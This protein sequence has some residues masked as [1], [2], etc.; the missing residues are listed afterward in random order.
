[1]P[2]SS[3]SLPSAVQEHRSVAVLAAR[4]DEQLPELVVQA[5][6]RHRAG[7]TDL[8][9]LPAADV[10]D[11]VHDA[12]WVVAEMALVAMRS[13]AAAA[14][15]LPDA[16]DRLTGLAAQHDAGAETVLGLL[17]ATHA[18]LLDHALGA[19]EHHGLPL[20][21]VER[22]SRHL[23][24]YMDRLVALVTAAYAEERERL[25]AR[26]EGARL[27]R[28]RAV[29]DGADR[30][31]LPYPLDGR[32][33]ALVLR[34]ARARGHVR[35]AMQRLGAPW[36]VTEEADGTVWAWVACGLCEQEVVRLLRDGWPSGCLV[37]VSGHESGVAGFRSTHRKAWMA[38]QLGRRRGSP[39]T[40]FSDIALEALAFG[41][42]QMARE[43]VRA[44]MGPL[45]ADTP[46]VAAMRETLSAY[47]EQGNAAAA[48]RE[49]GI[50]ERAVVYRLRHAEGLLER[51]LTERRA[52]LET[53]LR[54]H[55]MFVAA[56]ERAA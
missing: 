49:V 27:A 8:A 39:V 14:R 12:V 19:A 22:G 10:A 37:G 40:T 34:G 44:E 55:G 31:D 7:A 36:I 38:L 56:R 54:L 45:L 50:S 42:E 13:P 25:V 1:M 47:F 30:L 43:F 24:S 52:E 23:F 46:R 20:E 11:I 29:L 2:V 9:A 51:P 5:V 6:A 53:A 17:R 26:P 33:V 32:H 48:G 28:V 3:P 35:A 15:S 18:V 41:G 21:V 4:V 16:L